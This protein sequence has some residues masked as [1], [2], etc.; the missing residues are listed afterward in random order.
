ME[1]N[2]P[3]WFDSKWPG[4]S[5][6]SFQYIFRTNWPFCL[7]Q[8]NRNQNEG[9]GQAH[10][11]K[12]TTENP[13]SCEHI[14]TAVSTPHAL[15]I[16]ISMHRTEVDLLLFFPNANMCLSFELSSCK[17]KI[18]DIFVVVIHA[19][20]KAKRI[21]ESRNQQKKVS[22]KRGSKKGTPE[23]TSAVC[24]IMHGK[25][26]LR[27]DSSF[28]SISALKISFVLCCYCSS[29]H[30]LY[31]RSFNHACMGVFQFLFIYYYFFFCVSVRIL[32][33]NIM[34]V[35]ALRLARVQKGA[36]ASKRRRKYKR[37]KDD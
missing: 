5:V 14:Y 12:K 31:N 15:H 29:G 1:W 24:T 11:E 32:H 17:K 35:Y 10:S 30:V 33:Y 23:C 26:C 8:A 28:S 3:N 20:I 27:K 9:E 37:E 2:A 13:V 36:S 4:T 34:C 6:A 22:Q 16:C 21:M 25:I 7:L 18:F 19:F